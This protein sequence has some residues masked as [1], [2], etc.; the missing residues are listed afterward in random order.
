MKEGYEVF[1]RL[2]EIL[3]QHY[4]LGLVLFIVLGYMLKM[5]I[6]WLKPSSLHHRMIS[7]RKYAGE[8]ALVYFRPQPGVEWFDFLTLF[9]SL[10]KIQQ[11]SKTLELIDKREMQSGF[12][13]APISLKLDPKNLWI[14]FMADT[15]D[16]FNSTMTVFHALTRDH[17]QINHENLYRGK[18]LFIG[19]D[20]VYPDASEREYENRFKGPIRLLFPNRI[21]KKENQSSQPPNRTYLMA[22]PGNHDWYDGL[23]GFF[24]MMCQYKYIGDYKTVQHRSYFA[25]PLR[26]HIHVI[27]IDNQLLGDIDIPQ[28]EYLK[29]YVASLNREQ[30]HHVLLIVAEPYWYNYHFKERYQYRQRMDSLH[31]LINELRLSNPRLNF[32]AILAGDMHHYSR[33]TL[34]DNDKL[35][36]LITCGGGGAFKHLTS[37]LESF[38][39]VPDFSNKASTHANTY[40]LKSRYLSQKD[41]IRREWYNLF[42]AFRNYKFT[43]LFS[44]LNLFTVFLYFQNPTWLSELFFCALAPV[45][46]FFIMNAVESNEQA[47]QRKTQTFYIPITIFMSGL[48]VL[49]IFFLSILPLPAEGNTFIGCLWQICL[50]AVAQVTGY[51]VYLFLQYRLWGK[52]PTE[53]SSG[54]VNDQ[55]NCFLR[56]KIEDHKITF[57]AIGIKKNMKWSTG[58]FRN[59]IGLKPQKGQNIPRYDV[60]DDTELQ[61]LL[62]EDNYELIERY[63]VNL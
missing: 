4:F 35:R 13:K 20:L 37:R 31:Y 38:I 8:E 24:R 17:L 6:G 22:T 32:P 14:D 2:L 25:V 51:G 43:L 47:P 59:K 42:F 40:E 27:G 54:F 30:T 28:L 48:F 12:S 46:F 49:N 55:N 52:H 50:L 5:V 16:S 36:H 58:L 19:G 44:Y 39:E 3:N 18:V 33:Y 45:L 15:G 26:E 60:S 21:T 7:V 11:T 56:M 9:K 34:A 62:L 63:E 10:R 29:N 23:S 57:Y 53:A 41:S 61:S 1:C